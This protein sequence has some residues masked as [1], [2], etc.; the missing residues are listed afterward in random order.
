MLIAHLS[1]PHVRAGAAGAETAIGLHRALGRMLTLDRRPDCV[2]ITGDLV[3][4]GRPE[5]Y[6]VLVDVLGEFPVPVHVTAGNHDDP[7]L[8]ERR[9]AGTPQLGGGDR[10]F[11]AVDYDDAVVIALHSPEPQGP[12]G[13]LGTEQLAWLDATLARRP[14]TPAFVCLHHPPARVGIP[15][16]DGMGLRDAD[17]LREVLTAHPQVTRVLAGH[18]HR[19]VTATFA[20]TIV[21]VAPSSYRQS[22]LTMR[23]DGLMGYL[24]EPAGFLVHLLDG[25]GCVTHL[26]PSTHT[27][28]VTG[29][30]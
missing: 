11:Y 6:D 12:A 10:R 4:N 8:L 23:P 25:A 18:I 19:T 3:E 29:H 2:V 17:A 14:Q 9:F 5:Q 28:A 24:H 16:L 21:S 15:F 30:Y 1:D 26:V 7:D 13:R 20:G 27:S 22:T